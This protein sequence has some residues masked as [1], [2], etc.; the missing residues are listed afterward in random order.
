MSIMILKEY[1]NMIN[2]IIGDEMTFQLYEEL[3]A[4]E[5]GKTRD[6]IDKIKKQKTT[7]VKEIILPEQLKCYIKGLEF[8]I[9][10]LDSV[11]KHYEKKLMDEDSRD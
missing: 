2:L 9:Q 10:L 1:Q 7:N 8:S 3:L 6:Y 11:R 4:E 5:I